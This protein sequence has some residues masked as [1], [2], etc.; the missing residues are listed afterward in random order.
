MVE[1][2]SVLSRHACQEIA[3]FSGLRMMNE[4]LLHAVWACVSELYASG[5]YALYSL[6]IANLLVLLKSSLLVWWRL[7]K[8]WSCRTE[9]VTA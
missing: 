4:M 3:A 7:L 2:I 9:T 1:T 8:W 5:L 6:R